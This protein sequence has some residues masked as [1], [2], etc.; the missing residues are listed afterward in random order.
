[1]GAYDSLASTNGGDTD[2][3][4]ALT[5]YSPDTTIRATNVAG[6]TID[7]AWEGVALRVFYLVAADAMGQFTLKTDDGAPVDINGT[8]SKVDADERFRVAVTAV[9]ATTGKHVTVIRRSGEGLVS[10]LGV[11]ASIVAFDQ[12]RAV[13]HKL[14]RSASISYQHTRVRSHIHEQLAGLLAP[15][16]FVTMLGT[17]DHNLVPV[18]PGMTTA[19]IGEMVRRFRAGAPGVTPVISSTVFWSD[20]AGRL[21]ADTAPFN[22]GGSAWVLQRQLELRPALTEGLASVDLTSFMRQRVL[23]GGDWAPDD[24]RRYRFWGWTYQADSQ[25][26]ANFPPNFPLVPAEV[27]DAGLHLS[28]SGGLAWAD[29]I[30]PQLTT[31]LPPTTTSRHSGHEVGGKV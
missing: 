30:L 18:G 22:D 31:A 28:P 4:S 5:A 2:P 19:A 3:W 12:P 24:R 16:R 10:P 26:P 20:M 14:A 13:V 7:V 9:Q 23:T 21:G 11:D 6:P 15:D 27:T 29:W 17:N 25:N 1:M 8:D